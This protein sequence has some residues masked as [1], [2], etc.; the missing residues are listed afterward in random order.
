MRPPSLTWHRFRDD[1]T[2]ALAKTLASNLRGRVYSPADAGYTPEVAGFNTAVVHTPNLV[3]AAAGAVAVEVGAGHAL[4]LE[5]EG[6]G[7]A[8]LDLS[9]IHI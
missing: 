2:S 6:R 1:M 9:L 4:G 5:I 3:V 7:G 8:G